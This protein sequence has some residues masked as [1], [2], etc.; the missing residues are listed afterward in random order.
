[1]TPKI[2][3]PDCSGKDAALYALGYQRAILNALAFAIESNDASGNWAHLIDLCETLANVAH[4]NLQD[5]Q[6]TDGE[7]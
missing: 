4:Q 5:E 6:P 7:V 2:S 1:M 3:F